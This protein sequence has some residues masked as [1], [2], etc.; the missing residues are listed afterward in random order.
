MTLA[1]VRALIFLAVLFIGAGVVVIM[2]I[3]KDSQAEPNIGDQ[4]EPGQVRVY[5]H[6]PEN[7]KEIILNI[8]NGTGR[9]GEA[10][11]V[12]NAFEARGFTVNEVENPDVELYDGV[13]KLTF[14]PDGL[15]AGNLTSAY[16]LSG[17]AEK[18]FDVNR[19]G[20][21]IDV[22]LGTEFQQ[23]ATTTEVNQAIAAMGIPKAPP[24]VCYVP[25]TLPPLFPASES[26]SPSP[27][28]SASATPGPS[29][30]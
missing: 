29:P 6:M 12:A 13:A 27:S 15:G 23:L 20:R 3:G 21:E 18:V 16:F 28:A 19:E 2:A 11:R 9:R 26:P 8:Y 22:V 10:Q 7:R 4:C 24:G 17:S 30:S 5:T 14:G 1:R 25:G